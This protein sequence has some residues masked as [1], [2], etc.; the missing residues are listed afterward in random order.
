MRCATTC[1]LRPITC[2]LITDYF[3][4][5]L[6]AVVAE[7]EVYCVCAEHES[8]FCFGL[9]TFCFVLLWLLLLLFVN[10]SL[11]SAMDN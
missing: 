5:V 9:V 10:H 3:M 6:L 8:D 1:D 7:F 4:I 2:D 11:L